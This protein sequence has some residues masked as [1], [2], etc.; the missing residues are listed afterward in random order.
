MVVL[1]RAF[2]DI[3]AA[4]EAVQDAFAAAYTVANHRLPA[5]PGRMDHHHR[6]QSGHRPAPAGGLP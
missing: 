6:A 3:D 4:E 2:G 1:V 5:E